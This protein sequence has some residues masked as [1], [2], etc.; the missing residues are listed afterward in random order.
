MTVVVVSDVCILG[1]STEAASVNSRSTAALVMFCCTC[2][3]VCE[4]KAKFHLAS[5]LATRCQPGL[6]I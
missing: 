4:L 1:V 6:A 5:W 3:T 2:E